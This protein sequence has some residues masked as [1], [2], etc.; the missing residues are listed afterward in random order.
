MSCTVIISSEPPEGKQR[1][2]KMGA[3]TGTGTVA[4]TEVAGT[5]YSF[6][7]GSKIVE[8]FGVVAPDTVQ[9][10][11]DMS[12]YIRYSSSEFARVTPAKL[13]FNPVVGGLT[14][15]FSTKIDGVSRLPL[16]IPVVRGQVNIQDY[17]YLDT[18]PA[19]AGNWVSGVIIEA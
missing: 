16:D 3:L 9:A 15:N 19:A 17:V 14:T 2:A 5:Q 1:Y 18:A 12:G 10:A 13:E 11:D 8:L 4:S 6:S 7:K